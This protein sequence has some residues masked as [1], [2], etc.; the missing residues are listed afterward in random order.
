MFSSLY[1][2]RRF[3]VSI[4]LMIALMTLWVLLEDGTA[5]ILRAWHGMFG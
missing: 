2:L 3:L 5:P 1:A 4:V